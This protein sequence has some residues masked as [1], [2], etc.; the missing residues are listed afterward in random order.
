MDIEQVIT[1]HKTVPAT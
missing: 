1:P